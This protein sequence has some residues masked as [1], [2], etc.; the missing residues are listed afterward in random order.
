MAKNSSEKLGVPL[1]Y[2]EI[3]RLVVEQNRSRTNRCVFSELTKALSQSEREKLL[4]EIYDPYHQKVIAAIETVLKSKRNVIHISFHSFTQ[5]LDGEVR[6]A[7][8]GLL[9]DPSRQGEKRFCDNLTKYLSERSK[10]KIRR[11]YPY[12]GTSDGFTTVLRR[13]Y[14][15]GIYCGIEIEI[16]QKHFFSQSDKWSFL[17]KELPVAIAKCI[18]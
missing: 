7:D 17:Q 3:S 6:N 10:L 2:E 18:S 1:I 8:V 4:E 11:N 12:R 9:Y 15:A 5:V 14:G 13:L 16:N